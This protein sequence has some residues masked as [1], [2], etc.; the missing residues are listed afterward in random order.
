MIPVGWFGVMLWLLAFAFWCELV[1]FG[2]LRLPGF[3]CFNSVVIVT[4]FCLW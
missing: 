4:S 1:G 2:N 3:G